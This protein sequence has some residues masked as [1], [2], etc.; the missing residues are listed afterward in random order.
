MDE[1]HGFWPGRS[2]TTC[3][4]VF[5]NHIFKAFNAHS[6]IDVIYEDFMKDF[7]HVDHLSLMCV[8]K[9]IG[10]GDPLPSWSRSYIDNRKQGVKMQGI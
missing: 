10:F 1:Q 9:D 2:T 4:S 3:S 8:L 5:C 7:D 6:Q